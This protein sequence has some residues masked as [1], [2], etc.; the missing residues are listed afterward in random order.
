MLFRQKKTYRDYRKITQSSMPI[1]DVP[2]LKIFNHITHLSHIQICNKS[3]IFRNKLKHVWLKIDAVEPYSEQKTYSRGI[4][5]YR[6]IFFFNLQRGMGTQKILA[7]KEVRS[8]HHGCQVYTWVDP[9]EKGLNLQPGL[10][11][12]DLRETFSKKVLF[13]F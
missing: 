2:F 10:N 4:F 3:Q 6:W 5:Y 9:V 8:F 12:I 11:P 7:L 13:H 1:Q